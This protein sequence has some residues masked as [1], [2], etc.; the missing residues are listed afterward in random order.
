M[1]KGPG[2][3][4]IIAA[5]IAALLSLSACGH[6]GEEKRSVDEG[7]NESGA[8]QVIVAR[9]VS[10]NPVREAKLPADLLAYRDIAIYPKV[11][12]FIDRIGVDRGSIVKKGQVLIRM[13]APEL[14]A[15]A[16]E[17]VES[18]RSIEIEEVQ[19]K[20]ELEV[21]KQQVAAAEA[22]AAASTATYQRLKEAS[23]YPGII[24]GN[25][26]DIAH[27]TAEADSA[28]VRAFERK[29]KA[30][31]SQIRSVASKQKAAI[32]DAASSKSMESYLRLVAPFDGTIT[33]RNVHEGSFVSPP[34]SSDAQPLL[35]LQQLSTLRLTVPIPEADIGDIDSGSQ[36]KFTVSSYP[37]EH[38]IGVVRRISD[39]VDVSTR[40]MPVELDVE[41]ANRR[42]R[43]GMFAQVIWPMHR[44]TPTLWVPKTAVVKTTEKT[45]VIR[46]NGGVTEWI[47]VKSGSLRNGLIEVFGD[48]SD[49]D[50]VVV[51]GTDELRAGVHVLPKE[52][53]AP[54]NQS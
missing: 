2:G 5:W 34:S 17:G 18:A 37:R 45:F 3:F 51:R 50:Q 54:V 19:I 53:S 48:L 30:L 44:K 35:R 8:S 43:P 32:H 6:H 12:G 33:E 1:R 11:A 29:C 9:V 13:T 46:V 15:K 16:S 31:E 41:N 38:F 25:D 24:P 27:R 42:L 22:K 40:T 49:G 23:A 47:E 10:D 26:L 52:E 21:V 14:A 20:N 36:I 28:S 4:R 39:S 7:R